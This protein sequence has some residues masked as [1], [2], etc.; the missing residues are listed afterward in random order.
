NRARFLPDAVRSIKS[1]TLTDWELVVVDDGSTDDTRAVMDRLTAENRERVRYVYQ[2]NEGPYGAR[3]TGVG[4]SR[5][6]YVAFFDSDDLWLPFHLERCVAALEANPDVDWVCAAMRKVS[7][8]TGAVLEASTFH[9]GGRPNSF[10]SLRAEDRDGLKV[11]TDPRFARSC[12]DYFGVGNL[13]S[14]VLK[15]GTFERVSFMPFRTGEDRIFIILFLKEGMRFAYL[16]EVHVLYRVHDA[17]VSSAGGNNGLEK[18]IGVYDSLI[19]AYESLRTN[20][21]LSPTESRALDRRLAYEYFWHLGYSI[22]WE[23]GRRRDALTAFRTALRL[24]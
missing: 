12:I 3:N 8:E 13:Q 5:G 2:E 7:Y 18:R 16:D 24:Y 23:G 19:R 20:C 21:R 9:E 17:H 10:L 11:V 14:S 22:L 6:R 1:Q 15:R 4:H